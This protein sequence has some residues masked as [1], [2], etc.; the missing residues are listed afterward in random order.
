MIEFTEGERELINLAVATA[1]RLHGAPGKDGLPYYLHPLR[2][3]EKMM[4]RGAPAYVCI[5]AVLHDAVEDTGYTQG[6]VLRSF[7]EDA[8][9]VVDLISKPKHEPYESYI[10][11]ICLSGEY[12]TIVL[13]YEDHSDNSLPWRYALLTED[14]VRRLKTKYRTVKDQLLAGMSRAKRP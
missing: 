12:W 8:A 10:R 5:A 6:E 3:M 14:E 9:E 4:V 7:G 13:K 2:V 11:R 1:V